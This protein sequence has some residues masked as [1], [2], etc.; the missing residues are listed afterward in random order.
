MQITVPVGVGYVGNTRN[1]RD[2][3][4]KLNSWQK[5]GWSRNQ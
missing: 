1:M 5:Y 2:R 4:V 3:D